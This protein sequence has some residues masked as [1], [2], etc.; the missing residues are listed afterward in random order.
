MY[1]S[2]QPGIAIFPDKMLTNTGKVQ[3]YMSTDN[4]KKEFHETLAAV[5]EYA[6]VSGNHITKDTVHTYFKDLIQDESMYEFI[7]K[8]LADAKITIEGYEAAPP[9][10]SDGSDHADSSNSPDSVS[11][12]E[13]SD[14]PV[15][16]AADSPEATAFFEMYLDDLKHL[17]HTYGSGQSS[18]NY[19]EQLLAGLTAG[20]T[21]AAGALTE[22]YLPLVLELV[23]SFEHHGLTHSDLVAE[24][25]LALYE[26]VLANSDDA[27]G[28]DAFEAYLTTRITA[29]LKAAANEEIGSSRVS[30]HLADQVNALNDAATELA[31]E[32]GR[33]ATLEELCKHLS[34]GEDEVKELMKVSIQALTVVETE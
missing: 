30:S 16:E 4:Q 33:E 17:E 32:F 34:M 22:H 1:T 15:K 29:A 23:K 27:S 12:Y 18:Q 25:N 8:Y 21:A 19:V 13:Q 26:A 31:K 2:L 9:Q 5:V 7:Y 28:S 3:V 11:D 10:D 24:G 14:A 6:T 20:D